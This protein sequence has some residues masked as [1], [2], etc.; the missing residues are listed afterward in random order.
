MTVTLDRPTSLPILPLG[1]P[2]QG[3]ST[4]RITQRFSTAHPALDIGNHRAGD[5]VVA[6]A[7][8]TVAAAGYLLYPWSAPHSGTGTGNFGG[9]MTVTQHARNLWSVNAHLLSVSVRAGQKVQKGQPMAR[10]GGSGYAPSGAHLH[11]AVIVATGGELEALRTARRTV[12]YSMCRNPW[13]FPQSFAEAIASTML[14]TFQLDVWQLWR[15]KT[16]QPF[17]TLDGTRKEWAAPVETVK[18]VCE[19][20]L[21]DGTDARL[22]PYGAE[23]L[24]VP[25]VSLDPIDGGR[26]DP[27]AVQKAVR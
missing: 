15:T 12:P 5:A 23:M 17:Y 24:L 18:S 1:A 20:R 22:I 16:G 25:R 14:Y 27:R 10:I 19:I 8:G 13:P 3:F 4:H 11:Y 2:D 7:D 26:V 9:L 6:P 21:E